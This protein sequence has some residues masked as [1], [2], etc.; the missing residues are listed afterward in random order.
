M[1]R[2]RWEIV[3]AFL[4]FVAV[5]GVP[6]S[7]TNTV[8]LPP[9]LRLLA[10]DGS[11]GDSFG[12]AVGLSGDRVVI[13]AKFDEDNGDRLGSVYV[14]DADDSGGWTETKLVASD[15]TK[16][17]QFG[18]AVAVSGDR[19]VVGAF[20][21]DHLIGSAYVF[22]LDGAGGWVET[23]LV[24]S[25]RAAQDRFGWSVGVSG[26]RVVVGA[27]DDDNFRGSA[28]VFESDGGGGWVQK[29]LV[30]SHLRRTN[31]FG[32]SVAASGDRV[33]VGAWED[34]IGPGS[35]SVFEPNGAGG[36]VETNLVASDGVQG[37]RLG[38]S[39]A[40]SGDRVVA[41]AFGD[42]DNG[43][44]SGSVYVFESD[45]AGGW[46]ETKLLASD[47]AEGD[48]F[49]H[50][51]AVSGGWVV[52][53]APGDDGSG[54]VYVFELDAAGGWVETKLVVSDGSQDYRFGWS[55]GASGDRV[56]GGSPGDDGSARNS[57]SASVWSDEAIACD[58]LAATIIGTNGPGVLVGTDGPDVIVG[59]G[60]DD[61]IDP[62]RGDDVVCAGDGNDLVRPSAG[63]D[64][65]L[66]GTATTCSV[67]A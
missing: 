65:I 41:G 52:V 27:P 42:D 20:G 53:G 8:V 17:D 15:G 23:K 12:A 24:A 40:V 16:G 62:G 29:K 35:V 59:L 10:T 11:A 63:R 50:A 58:G 14:F 4:L 67:E 47:G 6:A 28:Y 25:D 66:G 3:S 61:D 18:F 37:D 5:V 31:R 49:G 56:V 55:V 57:G 22:D 64:V 32:W 13:G 19:V 2:R 21:A 39:V 51:V 7:A 44:T 26:D 1:R 48:Q 36:W 34:N 30:P 33:V 60:G 38:W 9:E 45:L 46:V 43:K 54:S